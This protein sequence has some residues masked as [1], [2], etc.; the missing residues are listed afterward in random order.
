MAG[1]AW[2][3]GLHALAAHLWVPS[4]SIVV[5]GDGTTDP[6]YRE[7]ES[8]LVVPSLAE[9]RFLV[10]LSAGRATA[11]ATLLAYN[12]LRP[13]SVRRRRRLVAAGIR[14]RPFANRI[15][16]QLRVMANRDLD[17]DGAQV[18]A[19]RSV[20]EALG[21]PTLVAA[22]GVPPQAPNSKPTLQ[23]FDP[24]GRPVAYAKLGWNDS[25][26]RQVA[27]EA[28]MTAR[29]SSVLHQ[30]ELPALLLETRWRG[31]DVTVTAAMAED[32]AAWGQAPPPTLAVTEELAATSHE[33]TRPLEDL[34]V[35][36]E[37]HPRVEG[38][39]PA[40]PGL[41][42]AIG[43]ALE[44]VTGEWGTHPIR[45]GAWHGDWVPWNLARSGDSIIA[46]DWE[47]GGNAAP[48]GFDLLHWHF[49]RAFIEREESVAAAFA[50]ATRES[51]GAVTELQDA[52]TAV[53]PC[54]ALYLLELTRRQ[55]EMADAGAGWN[56]RYADG[57]VAALGQLAAR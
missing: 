12:R 51:A 39:P 57:V 37:L 17:T 29:Y 2:S 42:D 16:D 3:P 18:S 10:P 21:N 43:R 15:G 13:P 19:V 30:V 40:V 34:P 50:F 56:P 28:R 20:G 32:A 11:A 5:T 55:L 47:H 49:Q 53:A 31:F 24:A 52:E 7:L 35:V 33:P 14:M 45:Q 46:W 54:A 6:D 9:A 48:V 4:D 27:N 44:V 36:R 38:E 8:Y 41:L 25:T 26:N 22:I 1:S 23:L